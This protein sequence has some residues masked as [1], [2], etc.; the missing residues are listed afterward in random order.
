IV[1]RPTFSGHLGALWQNATRFIFKSAENK[2]KNGDAFW[3]ISCFKVIPRPI[4]LF[5]ISYFQK[6]ETRK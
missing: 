4:S 3:H 5:G 1:A 2:Q 6:Q